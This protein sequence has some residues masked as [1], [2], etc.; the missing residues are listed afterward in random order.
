MLV[1]KFITWK[2]FE[3]FQITLF[4]FRRGELG[5]DLKAT[6]IQRSRD[7]GISSYN[8]IRNI[9]NL[10]VAKSFDDLI[11]IPKAVSRS[12]LLQNRMS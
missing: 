1:K 11:D 5:F 7:V 2:Q 4:W 8:K 10:S 9:C 12:T 6:D 3:Y